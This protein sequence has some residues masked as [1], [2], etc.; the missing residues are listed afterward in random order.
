VLC[1]EPLPHEEEFERRTGYSG[2]EGA[3]SIV[4][5]VGKK[6]FNAAQDQWVS[7]ELR[8]L[9]VGWRGKFDRKEPNWYKVLTTNP[10]GDCKNGW[11]VRNRIK[12]ALRE[13]YWPEKKSEKQPHESSG[14]LDLQGGKEEAGES[15]SGSVEPGNQ[16]ATPLPVVAGNGVPDGERLDH[17]SDATKDSDEFA[18]QTDG[19][20]DAKCAEIPLPAMDS[21][22]P[23]KG[24]G[25]MPGRPKGNGA[26]ASGAHGGGRR[27]KRSKP[28]G[29][30]GEEIVR[31]H[32][33][34]ILTREEADTIEWRAER[35]E[36]PGWDIDYRSGGRLLAVEVKS[37]VSP[38]FL[39]IEL[40][41]NE[42]RAA[43]SKG[44]NYRLALVADVASPSP[45]IEFLDDPFKRVTDGEASVEPV[46][47]KFEIRNAES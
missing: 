9:I 45:R 33:R 36:T 15:V 42:W 39:S 37:T 24:E 10:P 13:L 31:D 21:V 27:S 4:W 5:N 47:F 22:K 25:L 44:A 28:L 6:I 23:I 12:D 14:E 38:S 2:W 8:N 18:G 35:G 7:P 17:G 41:A 19:V 16:L 1:E 11:F 3:N 34:E 32:L 20:P 30:R 43:E 40:T 26:A 29:D 46:V